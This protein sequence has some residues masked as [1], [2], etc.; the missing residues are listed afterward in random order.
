MSGEGLRGTWLARHLRAAP[1]L[2]RVGFAS[3][4]AYRAEMVVWILT[5]S[6]PLVM[7]ALWNA[8]AAEGPL[9]GFGQAEFARYFTATL[10]VRQLTGAWIVWELNHQ[11]RTGALSPQLLRPVHPLAQNL[12]ETAAAVPFRLVVLA[13]ILVLL[14]AWRPDIA[15]VPSPAQALLGGCSV[16]LAFLLSWLVQ[17]IFGML[18]FWLEQSLGLFSLWFAAYALLGGYFLPVALLPGPVRAAAAW[19]PFQATLATPVEVLLG[20][21]ADPVRAVLV[22]LVWVALALSVCAVMWRRGLVR[23]GAVGA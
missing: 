17:A 4:V 1:T 21:S 13:P 11:V 8:A 23:Y 22:Q 7:L 16:V 18:A 20:M 2:L 9:S 14:L 6:L 10:V 5:A 19:L 15:W 12:A 3:M